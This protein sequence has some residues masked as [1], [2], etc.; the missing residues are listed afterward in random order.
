VVKLVEDTVKSNGRG[1][2]SV[3]EV[4]H[5]VAV[6]VLVGALS[7]GDGLNTLGSVSIAILRRLT[8]SPRL[9]QRGRCIDGLEDVP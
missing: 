7:R 9:N 3:A 1:R 8:S 6:D 5:V 2:T 4:P